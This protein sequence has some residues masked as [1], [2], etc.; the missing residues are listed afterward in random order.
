M[1]QNLHIPEVESLKVSELMMAN[2]NVWSRDLNEA[3]LDEEGIF[4]ELRTPI[5]PMGSED[6]IIWHFTTVKLACKLAT[7]I[8]FDH[9]LEAVGDWSSLWRLKVLAKVK[10]CLWRVNRDCIP[11]KVNLRSKAIANDT[12][13]VLCDIPGENCWHLFSDCHYAVSCWQYICLWNL[14]YK[15]VYAAYWEV[16]KRRIVAML[17]WVI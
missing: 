4:K 17:I 15:V 12:N 13:C 1:V 14:V 8:A 16:K 2:T 3:I 7:M 6:M 11:H 9:S 10:D 5:A